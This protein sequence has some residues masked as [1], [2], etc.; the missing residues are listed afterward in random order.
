M[1][2]TSLMLSEFSNI[3]LYDHP[4]AST[5]ILRPVLIGQDSILN[6]KMFW[7]ICLGK[8]S[9]SGLLTNHPWF[10]FV[11]LSK[12]SS[13]QFSLFSVGDL[14]EKH[15]AKNVWKKIFQFQYMSIATICFNQQFEVKNSGI[16]VSC[17]TS[18]FNFRSQK[19][20][21]LQAKSLDMMNYIPPFP[22]R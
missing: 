15:W 11:D 14:L 1:Q 16:L 5:L 9:I 21:M 22:C 2:S 3:V 19:K 17:L 7:A 20:K 4:S 10:N 8:W 12:F 6:S 18:I 13:S